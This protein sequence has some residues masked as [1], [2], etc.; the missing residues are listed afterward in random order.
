MIRKY[1]NIGCNALDLPLLVGKVVGLWAG[2]RCAGGFRGE[3]GGAMELFRARTATGEEDS[4]WTTPFFL[5]GKK[6]GNSVYFALLK[7]DW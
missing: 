4:F 7:G 2:T 5:T 1:R 6:N 3:G